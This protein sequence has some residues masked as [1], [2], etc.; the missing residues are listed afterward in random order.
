MEL[1]FTVLGRNV[2]G[3][4]LGVGRYD[5]SLY[6]NKAEMLIEIIHL[7]FHFYFFTISF[8][9]EMPILA[10][11]SETISINKLSLFRSIK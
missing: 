7:V 1:P 11:A 4:G 5:K 6:C 2:D 3:A 9:L 8:I 10:F